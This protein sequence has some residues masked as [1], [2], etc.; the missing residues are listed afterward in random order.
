MAFA[1]DVTSNIPRLYISGTEISPDGIGTAINAV[2]T[3]PR[4]TAVNTSMLRKPPTPTGFWYRCSVAG[5]TAATAPTYGTT[6]G[7]TTTDGTSTW[8][9]IR[10]SDILPIGTKNHY[11]MPDIR[12]EIV[13]T[14]TNANNQI[15][16]F[17]CLDIILSSASSNFTSGAW[18]S[19]GV[20]PLYDGLHFTTTL[21]TGNNVSPSIQVSAGTM[22]LIGGEVQTAAAVQISFGGAKI[23]SYNTRWRSTRII[24]GVSSNRFRAYSSTSVF[25]NCEF[26]DMA[27]DL[28]VMPA[29]FSVVARDSEYVAQYVGGAYGGVDAYFKASALSNI[30]GS[31]DFDNYSGGY[32]ELFN[33]SKA[34]NLNVVTQLP[35]NKLCVPLYQDIRITAKDTAGVVVPNVRFNTTDIPNNSPTVT[36]TVAGN[37]KTWDFRNPLSYQTTTN[38]SGIALSSPISHV[39]YYN[40]ALR[41]NLRFPLATNDVGV[42]LPNAIYQGR[43]Y[44]YKTMSVSVF[45]GSNSTQDV[46]AGMIA[47]DT[48]T[49]VDETT[50]G[51]ITGISLVPSGAT[52]GTITISSNK[53]YQDI[54]NYYRYWISQFGNKASNDT[55]TCTGGILNTQNWNIVVNSGVTLTSSTNITKLQTLGSIT[56]NGTIQAIYQDSTGTS[57][58]LQI[59][60]FDAGSSVYVEDNLAV[61]K[62]YSASATGTVTVYI[63][64]TGT[65]SWYYAVEKY[66]NQRQSDFFTFS[67][68]I[69]P[70]VV[71]AIPDTGLTV[72][73]SAT[74]GAYTALET[75]D[76]VYD[77]V[78]F[79]RLSVPHISY[80]QIVFKDGTAL[81]LQDADMIVNQ[82]A[83]S[84]A[85]FNYDTKVLTVK[86]SSMITGVTYNLIKTTPPKTIEAATTEVISVNIE[87][88]NGDSSVN[89]Q[90][91]SGNFTLWKITNATPEDQYSTGTNLGNVGNENYRFLSAPGFKIV[92]R[93]NTT[94]FRQVVPMDK[95]NYTRGLFFGDQVQL[96]QSQEVT[97]INTKVDILANDIDAIKG[98]GFTKDTHS[99]INIEGY[100]DAI[101]TD[102]WSAT[103]RTLTTSAGGATLAEIEGSTVLAK[104]AAATANKDAIITAIGTGGG[105]SCDL[106]GIEADLVSIKA[107]TNT[108]E[109]A[110]SKMT[111]DGHYI[112]AVAKVVEDKA[113]YTLTPDEKLNIANAVQAAILNESDGQKILEAIVNA[114]GNENI[115]QVA[116]V[117]AIRADIERTGG[118]LATRSSEAN[119]TTNKVAILT[120]VGTP[121]QA[122]NYTAPDNATIAKINDVKAKTDLIPTNTATQTDIAT[123]KTDLESSIGSFPTK[124]EISTEVWADEPERL[125]R[126]A[127]VETTG[128]QLAAF[129]H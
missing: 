70:I 121:L 113:N 43:A 81:D 45:L 99:L 119:A 79:L 18:A 58:T 2:A 49:T 11:Y 94:G 76:K 112:N 115:D 39:W 55:W 21:L 25:R 62:F 26:Y 88:A 12:V 57:T 123:L 126:V 69:L 46:S 37:L 109:A 7:G 51:A 41:K 124:E 42:S 15:S 3:V 13:G 65:G 89:I 129:N 86:S 84:V 17:T 102:V 66:G 71:K 53:S 32:V 95:G 122:A 44:N 6:L 19:D 107:S 75:P 56:N 63:P 5:T 38:A 27:Y 31:Y 24:G 100:V 20:T 14:F 61:Q 118:V 101:P 116:L 105:G 127:T 54:W 114:I 77:Y 93:D 28:F 16:H 82:S 22:T 33:C 9:A 67:G 128:N 60:G 30:D 47:L 10:A 40:T 80:G 125:K 8:V 92:I 98:T 91:G 1:F 29:E 108:I 72:L 83:T 78:A 104:E 90:G 103:T 97:Q 87:D 74:V 36:I 106:T 110:T 117:A 52:G 85:S 64:P 48:A 68:G 4:S 50:A 59:S 35:S 111:F 34:H 23:L 120:A 96:A 73:N